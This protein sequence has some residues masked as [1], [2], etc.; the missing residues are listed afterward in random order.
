[1][2]EPQSPAPLG[3][4]DRTTFFEEQA[5][6]RRRTHHFAVA[7]ALAVALAGIPVSLVVSPLLYLVTLTV[8]HLI[9][10][11][12]PLPAAFW[13]L[14]DQ[15]GRFLPT[16][17]HQIDRAIQAGNW[18]L[19]DLRALGLLGMALVL[20]G[21]ALSVVAWLWVRALLHRVGVGGVLT[22]IGARPPQEDRLEERQLVNLVEEMGIAGGLRRPR[23]M[24]LD[25][26]TPNAAAIGR[27]RDDATIVVTRGLLE[28]LSRDQT[29]A[30]IGHLVGSI[31]N[32]DLEIA[33]LLLAVFQTYALLTVLLQAPSSRTAR[34]NAWRAVKG[35]VLRDQAELEQVADLLASDDD[36]KTVGEADEVR[37]VLGLWRFPFIIVGLTV[38]VL[39]TVGTMLIVGPALGALWRTRRYLA[40]ACAV[41]LTRNPDGMAGALQKLANEGGFP[42]GRSSRLLFVV[43][44]GSSGGGSG[45]TIPGGLHP[46]IDRRI[47]RLEATGAKAAPV[48]AP[49]W[50][51]HW[52]T[53]LVAVLMA[54]VYL[55][56]AAALVMMVAAAIFLT[57]MSLAFTAAAIAFV[58]WF[59]GIAPHLPAIARRAA[60]IGQELVRALQQ[61]WAHRR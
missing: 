16:V 31:G 14:V 51:L 3:P 40:D 17:A 7:S 20:P 43:W 9:Q 49:H 56:M 37:T 13:H 33:W 30:V 41:Q 11:A 24:L 55:V 50:S 44:G 60:V 22:R 19:L 35:L 61:L 25:V 58:H 53:P 6:R 29:Q 5:R 23:V 36:G 42:A 26:A 1:M 8:A 4:A 27:N 18:R 28:E 15:A 54:V 52:W 12:T 59:F 38:Q 46:R 47:R 45:P 32:G 21:I 10:L 34:R 57:G 2:T 39:V 48:R